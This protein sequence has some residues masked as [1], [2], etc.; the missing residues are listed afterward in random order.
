[1]LF[2]PSCKWRFIYVCVIRKSLGLWR[3]DDPAECTGTFRTPWAMPHPL[4]LVEIRQGD[5]QVMLFQPSCKWRFSLSSWLS[6]NRSA[7]GMAM[8]QLSAQSSFIKHHF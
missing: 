1:M 6:A 5:E 2:Q 8:I 3:G 7:C 4:G